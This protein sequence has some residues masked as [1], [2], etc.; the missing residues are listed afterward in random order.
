MVDC[1]ALDEYQLAGRER[2][3]EEVAGEVETLFLGEGGEN[4]DARERRP[5]ARHVVRAQPLAV[6]LVFRRQEHAV[7]GDRED[8]PE[9]PLD[10]RDDGRCCAFRARSASSRPRARFPCTRRT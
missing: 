4:R 10:R 5:L 1:R 9:S 2:R 3:M 8:D 6:L 7:R